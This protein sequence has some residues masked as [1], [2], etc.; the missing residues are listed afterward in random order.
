M[1]KVGLFF[2][3]EKLKAAIKK[4]LDSEHLLV[5]LTENSWQQKAASLSVVIM[6][7]AAENWPQKLKE[8]GC[9][10]VIVISSEEELPKVNY[11]Y[12]DDFI[13][14]PL[15]ASELKLRLARLLTAKQQ[16]K[17]LQVDDL[18]IDTAKY[19]VLIANQPLELTYKEYELLKFLVEH[20]EQVWTRQAL[21]NRIWEYDYFGG[22]R[23]V[24]VHIRRLRAKLGPKYSEFLQT[25]RHV[26]YKWL[27]FP[28]G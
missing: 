1:A 8:A 19:E 7:A 28:G 22:T 2:I 3:K 9:G 10:G 13:V 24:D 17:L 16:K 18:V 11:N 26:G 15:K 4:A 6:P 27:K 5:E 20:P 14:L 21:L 25:V 23:T 12:A